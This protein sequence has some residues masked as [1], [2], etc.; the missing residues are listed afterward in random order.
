VGP[1]YDAA[2]LLADAHLAAREDIVRLTDE[3]GRSIAMPAPLPTVEAMPGQAR[4]LGPK[5]GQGSRALLEVLGFGEGAV[6][7]LRDSGA[8]W[9]FD[10]E[11][12][13]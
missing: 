10:G 3:A 8:L 6:K 4:H 13:S 12:R 5:P 1:I 9:A 7:T 11:S 2:D